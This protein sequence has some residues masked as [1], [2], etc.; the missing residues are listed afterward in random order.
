MKNKLLILALAVTPLLAVAQQKIT[1]IPSI[2]YAWRTAK[3]SDNMTAKQKDYVK[4][5]KSGF[6]FDIGAYH[7]LNTAIGIGLKYN[8]YSTSHTGDFEVVNTQQNEKLTYSGFTTKDRISFVGPGFYYSNFEEEVKHKMY[9]D[10]AVGVISYSSK[11]DFGEVKGSNLGLAATIGYM[12]ELMP[13]LMIGPQV[14]FTGGALKKYKI[15]GVEYQLNEGEYEALHRV[16]V[17]LGATFR[18]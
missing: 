4:G 5:L 16:A 12:Y 11:S 7:R 1:I 6:N 13:S 14:S 8:L 9:Y 3:I 15:N 2:G 18:F 10:M 17:S